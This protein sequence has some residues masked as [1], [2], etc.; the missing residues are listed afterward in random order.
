MHVSNSVGMCGKAVMIFKDN[1]GKLEQAPQQQV[2][3]RI[4]IYTVSTHIFCAYYETSVATSAILACMPCTIITYPL[5]CL[6]NI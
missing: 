3:H 5:V 4:C 6:G 2:L 1:W